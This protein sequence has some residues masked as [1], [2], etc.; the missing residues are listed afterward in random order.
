MQ[1]ERII[2]GENEEIVWQQVNADFQREPD[3]F[4]Y[5]ITLQQGERRILL[6]IDIDPGGGIEAGFAFTTF[7]A[8]L[9]NRNDFRFA[10]HTKGFID[11]IGKFFGMQDIVLGYS[12]FDEKFIVKTNEEGKTA[13]LFA[14]A[15]IRETLESLPAL[16]FGIVHYVMKDSGDKV[17][18][19]E[20]KMDT[21]ITDPLKL[22]QIYHAFYS[23]L[24]KLDT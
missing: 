23:V 5:H 22:R 15:S 16:T 4:Q 14:D 9:Y 10:I 1:T 8:Y 6:D 20:L 3:P 11:E 7:G 17:P 13:T 18:F 21:G 19:L 12:E 24:T 2:S